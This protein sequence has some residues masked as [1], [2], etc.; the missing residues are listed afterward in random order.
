MPIVLAA[1]PSFEITIVCGFVH[2]VPLE[3]SMSLPFTCNVRGVFPR[4][5]PSRRTVALDGSEVI[6]SF[7]AN[8]A[9]GKTNA[10]RKKEITTPV[11][12]DGLS[13]ITM[14]VRLKEQNETEDPEPKKKRGERNQQA[15]QPTRA[16]EGF[17]SPNL[18]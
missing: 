11:S 16:A 12:V 1:Q 15:F 4:Y 9:S 2:R 13:V 7:F 8:D 10:K 17:K 14:V 5:F 6:V 3:S 18:G